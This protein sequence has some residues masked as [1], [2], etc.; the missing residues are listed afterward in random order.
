VY[1]PKGK[2]RWA[3][4]LNAATGLGIGKAVNGAPADQFDDA[5]VEP[6]AAGSINAR[7]V[8]STA[9]IA[10]A[11]AALML[12]TFQR[13]IVRTSVSARCWLMT[14]SMR[15]ASATVQHR[16]VALLVTLLA[17]IAE[18]EGDLIRERTGDGRRRAMANGVKFGRLSKLSAF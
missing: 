4:K 2:S 16:F 6:S 15:I 8:I 10:A 18:F 17:A 11:G 14:C 13:T 1:I 7:H 9:T 12:A 5:G 3:V